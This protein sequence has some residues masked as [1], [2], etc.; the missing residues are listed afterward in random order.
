M[1]RITVTST[2]DTPEQVAAALADPAETPVVPVPEAGTKTEKPVADPPK[3]EP[4]ETPEGE[5]PVAE[6]DEAPPAEPEADDDDDSVAPPKPLN[7]KDRIGRLKYQRWQLRQ[8]NQQLQVRLAEAERGGVKPPPVA[9]PEPEPEAPKFAKPKPQLGDFDGIEEWTEALTDWTRESVEFK[10]EQDKIADRARVEGT[11]RQAAQ[12]D[13]ITRHQQRVAEFRK[14][15]PDFD[16][17]AQ[18]AI[19]QGIA[20]KMTPT[21]SVHITH[22]EMGPELMYHL[23]QHPDELARIASLPQGPALVAIGR[24]EQQLTDVKVAPVAPPERPVRKPLPPPIKPLGGGGSKTVA[25]HPDD[26]TQAEYKEWR[27]AGGGRQ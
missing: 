26:M 15:R 23:A 14:V 22:S 17:V 6:G 9:E 13:V 2:T 24:L 11:Q 25:K 8:S 3:D 7:K 16:T 10:F 21:M 20:E 19:D 5:A 12:S 4:K 1:S 27:R 18:E